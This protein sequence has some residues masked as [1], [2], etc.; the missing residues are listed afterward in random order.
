[1]E[2]RSANQ[3]IQPSKRS[4]GWVV[5]P[6][7]KKQATAFVDS[8][9]GALKLARTMVRRDGGGEVRVK[10]RMGK[11]V[12]AKTVRGNPFGRRRRAA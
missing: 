6:A 3:T 12:E 9:A 10:N 11:V 2:R 4:D 1:M 7:G 5:V 8:K